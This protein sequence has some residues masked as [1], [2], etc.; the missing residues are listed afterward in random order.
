[1]KNE[2]ECKCICYHHD[3]MDGN[4]SG[5]II[6]VNYGEHPK[7]NHDCYDQ[8]FVVDFSFTSDEMKLLNKDNKLVWIDHHI[9]A[10]DKLHQIWND[11]N[12]KGIRKL[13]KSGCELTWEYLHPIKQIPLIVEY[14]GDRDLWN[15]DK[16]NTKAIHEYLT[17]HDHF[18]EDLIKYLH[19]NKYKF[20]I[21][22][23][24]IK[25]VKLGNLLLEKKNQ[26]VKKSFDKGVDVVFNGYKTRVCNDQNNISDL[27]NFCCQQGYKIGLVWSFKSG[28]IV[29]SLRSSANVDVSLIAQKYEG[30]GHFHSSGFRLKNISDLGKIIYNNI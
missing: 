30:G 26:Q 12:I 22:A 28:N 15:F 14:I 4:M 1:M 10:K 29:V 27:G 21:C 6:K 23:S 19:L 7:Q 5:A 2:I 25:R 16:S 20:D 9:S 8:I 18:P 17:L 13:D 3:D 11:T 24:I